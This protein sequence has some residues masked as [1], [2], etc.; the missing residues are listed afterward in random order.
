MREPYITT[1]TGKHFHPL[2]PS[3][4]EI[5]IGDIAHALPLICRGN[6][7]VKTFFSV[8]QHC[9]HCAQEAEARGYEPRLVLAC[10]I[11]DASECYMSDLPRPF[12]QQ[13]K[14][15]IELEEKLLSMIY[16]KFLGSDLTAEEQKLVKMID[17]DMLYWDLL[18]LLDE[19]TDRPAP[20]MN[21][22]FG[23][24]M[25]P[26]TQVEDKYLSLFEKYQ[27]LVPGK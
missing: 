23:Y 24:D 27:L 14:T 22:E 20:V 12:K 3:P 8:G 19:K 11:H 6:G 10:L 25:I 7:H 5:D 2:T 4:D 1:Y 21:S 15:Y 18:R 17:D 26:F 13:M 16:E 9:I